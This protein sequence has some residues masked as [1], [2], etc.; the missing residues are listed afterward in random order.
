MAD[1]RTALLALA[2]A[3][4]IALSAC[5]KPDGPPP[6][7]VRRG[8]TEITGAPPPG[9][10]WKEDE[11]TLPPYP[12]K[13]D[14][15]EFYPTNRTDN[16]YFVDGTSLTVGKD[17]VVRF[18]LVIRSRAGVDN[19]SYAGVHCKTMQWKSYAYGGQSGQWVAAKSPGW[20]RI[21]EK[22][23]NNYQATLAN[24]FFCY[25][26]WASGGV[27]GNAKHLVRLLRNPPPPSRHGIPEPALLR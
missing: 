9:A 23:W 22:D 3:A 18:P 5:G 19:L 25:G 2:S 20:S 15:I 21:T 17:G 6:T 8:D 4:L 1:V 16:R 11:V 24:D 10:P 27:N 14:L 12:K 26:G 13:G 7:V